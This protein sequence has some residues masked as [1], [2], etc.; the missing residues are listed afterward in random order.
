MMGGERRETRPAIL[1]R[2]G[3]HTSK[4]A[5]SE[6]SHSPQ[7]A[8]KKRSVGTVAQAS[9]FLVLSKAG[10]EEVG[11]TDIEDAGRSVREVILDDVEEEADV[12]DVGPGN[13]VEEMIVDSDCEIIESCMPKT[14][15]K[16]EPSEQPHKP[17]IANVEAP[18]TGVAESVK[19][20]R[21][22]RTPGQA[23]SSEDIR[24]EAAE[25]RLS[26]F[27]GP[28]NMDPTARAMGMGMSTGRPPRSS[29]S[30]G[31]DDE[32][33]V[34]GMVR[35]ATTG[36]LDSDDME[37]YPGQSKTKRPRINNNNN[38][39]KKKKKTSTKP[40]YIVPEDDAPQQD[41]VPFNVPYD[42]AVPCS[43]FYSGHKSWPRPEGYPDQA[44]DRLLACSEPLCLA[45]QTWFRFTEYEDRDTTYYATK[46]M[47]EALM[48]CSMAESTTYDLTRRST[49]IYT[50]GKVGVSMPQVSP[51][52]GYLR[53]QVIASS[54]YISCVQGGM[55]SL[56][57]EKYMPEVLDSYSEKEELTRVERANAFT[58]VHMG[59][60]NG[61]VVQVRA[62]YDGRTWHGQLIPKDL[63]DL[64]ANEGVRKI[65]FGVV[66]DVSI[67]EHAGIE[68]RSV[69][70]L[71]GVALMLW[72]QMEAKQPKTGKWFVKDMLRS[73]CPIY[74]Y[75]QTK[76]KNGRKIKYQ[77]MDFALSVDQ[78]DP[79]WSFYNQ[80]DHYLAYAL[81]DYASARAADLDGL[82]SDADVVRYALDLLDAVRD[83]PKDPYGQ[84]RCKSFIRIK[85]ETEAERLNELCWPL[86]KDYDIYNRFHSRVEFKNKLPR[87][88]KPDPEH[89][90]V[91]YVTELERR[92]GSAMSDWHLEPRSGNGGITGGGNFPHA[93][94]KCGSC[95]H[96]RDE[97]ASTET[98]SYPLC[99]SDQHSIFVCPMVMTRCGECG[100]L[101][102]DKH[103]GQSTTVLAE[104]FNTAKRV[105]LIAS[106]L[107]NRDL[108][109]VTRRNEVMGVL[110]VV[111][112]AAQFPL[113]NP[114]DED[115]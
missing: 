54:F 12:G 28:A 11:V 58:V 31:S 67:L 98:C 57:I 90:S 94:S 27:A 51:T 56:D 91:S 93:C 95:E 26:K 3:P 29:G 37:E 104:Y 14:V 10:Q 38:N 30:E 62:L 71:H 76:P 73:P 18:R 87:K 35:R 8:D 64:L 52:W 111:E 114:E 43:E 75:G 2:L 113:P 32:G 92:M 59:A 110:G 96:V 9:N 115:V 34:N 74:T 101:G 60:P 53:P 80:M 7:N 39:K 47:G 109:F 69:C 22:P 41:Q 100:G 72:P 13:K 5:P 16:Q 24:D 20:P 23:P 68:C 49:K 6:T 107:R 42:Q 82:K 102:H 4:V 55:V 45:R 19:Q 50:L 84:R 86:C 66:D 83:L 25:A 99:V 36:N 1:D 15:V 63:T 105:H 103:N 44:L 89:C 78:W 108:A 88:H 97:C 33:V 46:T 65:G 17:V 112:V 77:E 81:V 106:R 85:T 70:D 61:V 48:D 40:K 21:V 79:L